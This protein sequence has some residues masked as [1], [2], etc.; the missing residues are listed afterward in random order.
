M[1]CHLAI[2]VVEALGS[3]TPFCLLFAVAVLSARHVNFDAVQVDRVELEDARPMPVPEE[4]VAQLLAHGLGLAREQAQVEGRLPTRHLHV[5]Q[6]SPATNWLAVLQNFFLIAIIGFHWHC[7]GDENLDNPKNPISGQPPKSWPIQI[8][9]SLP[10]SSPS[11]RQTAPLHSHPQFG[12][13]PRP[14]RQLM[15]LHWAKDS[16]SND[17]P[18]RQGGLRKCT[19]HRAGV[20]EN[21]GSGEVKD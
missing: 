19:E 12:T 3:D 20:A 8:G 17:G 5:H 16:A 4:N 9:F 15:C 21:K 1:C 2:W 14:T 7:F 11:V 18:G 13:T 6:R 10:N